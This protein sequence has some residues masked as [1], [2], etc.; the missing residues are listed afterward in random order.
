M[1]FLLFTG[2]FMEVTSFQP[3]YRYRG[4]NPFAK[5]HGHPSTC[6]PRALEDFL[7]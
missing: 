7:F 4:Y 2:M 5:Y 1:T 6:L 3:T